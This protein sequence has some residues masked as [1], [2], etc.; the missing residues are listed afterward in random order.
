MKVYFDEKPSVVMAM[1]AG[2][3]AYHYDIHEEAECLSG[4]DGKE[5]EHVQWAC[6]EV[7]IYIRP[8]CV[9]D[10][11]A[12]ASMVANNLG[13]L[14]FDMSEDE[15]R[16]VSEAFGCAK[17]L[18]LEQI[19]MYDHSDSVNSFSYKGVD[20]W[21]AKETRV[22]LLNRLTAEKTLGIKNTTLWYGGNPYTVNVED[23]FR[24]LYLLENYASTA[25]DV[26][27]KHLANVAEMDDVDEIIAYNYRDGYPERLV[28][29]DE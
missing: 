6:E 4:S 12:V 8:D 15:M 7:M 21:L 9:S 1:G 5:E 10:T 16:A 14:L 17:E 2:Y 24:L 22:G 23:G 18:K 11:A 25:Y 13:D 19:S 29:G 28:L 27:Q 26:T 3:Y 20:M